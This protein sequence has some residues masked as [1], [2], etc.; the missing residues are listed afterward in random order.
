MSRH[1]VGKSGYK[2]RRNIESSEKSFVQDIS[3]HI[4]SNKI[5]FSVV[6]SIF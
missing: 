2:I 1:F 6:S 3:L 5:S 4:Y